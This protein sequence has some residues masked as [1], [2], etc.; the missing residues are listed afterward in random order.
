MLFYL[1]FMNWIIEEIF[2]P[3]RNFK[4]DPYI[5]LFLNLQTFKGLPKKMN[6]GENLKD[7]L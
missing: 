6:F 5:F 1:F 3:I 7:F 2:L 4:I